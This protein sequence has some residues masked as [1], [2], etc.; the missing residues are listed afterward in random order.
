MFKSP[1]RGRGSSHHAARTKGWPVS[2]R[3]RAFLLIGIIAS[4]LAGVAAPAAA[5]AAPAATPVLNVGLYHGNGGSSFQGFNGNGSAYPNPQNLTSWGGG[6]W[7][8]WGRNGSTDPGGV[9]KSTGQSISTLTAIGPDG[10]PTGLAAASGERPFTFSWS[11]GSAPT[12]GSAAVAGVL[13]QAGGN[14]SSL[15]LSAKLTSQVQRLRVWVSAYDGT[16]VFE[17]TVP[18]LPKYTNKDV[19][20]KTNDHGGVFELDV[21]G[22]GVVDISYTLECPSNGCSADSHV[23]VYAA[24]Y[25]WKGDPPAFSV[26]VTAGQPADFTIVQGQTAPLASSVTT[27]LING[28]VGSVA[29]SSSV[30][31]DAGGSASGLGV[32][33]NP[34]TV[35]PSGGSLPTVSA[36]TITPAVDIA[37]GTY[38]ITV[39][40]VSPDAADVNTANFSVAVLPLTQV[41]FLYRAFPNAADTDGVAPEYEG[42][43]GGIT[44]TGVMN[45]DKSQTYR[46]QFSTATACSTT[47]VAGGTLTAGP[48]IEISTDAQG[49]A[50]F[51]NSVAIAPDAKYISAK[52][53][54]YLAKKADGTSTWTSLGATEAGPCIVVSQPN[55]SWPWAL[56]I[57]AGTNGLVDF[58]ANQYIDDFARSRWYMFQVQPGSRVHVTISNLPKD[59]DAYL[60][61]DI[62][63]AYEDGSGLLQQS[64]EFAPPSYAPPS[65]APPSYAPDS[66]APPSYAPPSY[67]PPSYAPPSYAPPSY[68]PPSYAPPSYAPPSY[69]PPSYAPPSYAPPSY[70]QAN[71]APPSYAP[72]SYAL[73]DATNYSSA[74]TRSLI[75]WDVESGTL[76]ATID[77]NTWNSTGNFYLRVNGKSGLYDIEQAFRVTITTD[78]SVCD[79][80]DPIGSAPA[81]APAAGAETLILWNSQRIAGTSTEKAALVTKL[82]HL[83]SRGDVDGVVVDLGDTSSPFYP[84]MTSL[85]QQADAHTSCVYAQ[86]LVASAARDVV[87]AY[88]QSNPGLKYVVLAGGDD[89]IPFFRYPDPAYLGPES[90][91]VPPVRKDSASEASLRSNYVLGQDEYGASTILSLGASRIPIPDLAVGRLAESASDVVTMIDAYAPGSSATLTTLTPSSAL[92]TGYDFLADTAHAVSDQLTTGMAASATTQQLISEYGTATD[93]SWTAGDLRSALLGQR[94]DIVFLAGH[95]S[96]NEALAAD[97]STRMN[98]S[99]LAASSVNL[100]NSLVF[101]NGCHSGYNLV[102]GAAITGVTE[103]LDWAQAF[104]QKGATLIAGT[105]Y[106]YGDTDLLEYSERIYAEFARQLRVGSGPVSV[107]DALNAAK[108]AYMGS[109]QHL[110]GL[111]EKSIIEAALFGLPMFKVNMTG[112][113]DT[114]PGSSPASLSLTEVGGGLSWADLASTSDTQK[115][116]K[117]L[118]VL[119][120]N[121]TTAGSVMTFWYSGKDGTSVNPGDPILPLDARNV[122]QAGKVL[123]GVVLLNGTYR[124]RTDLSVDGQSYPVV[125]LT[126]TA[127][128]ELGGT[129]LAFGSPTFYPERPWSINY[130]DELAGGST[131]LLLTPAQHRV[132]VPGAADSVLRLYSGLDLRLYYLDSSV[133]PDAPIAAALAPSISN[134]RATVTGTSVTFQA[135]VLGDPTAG[136]ALD[137]WITYTLGPDVDGNGT[138]ASVKLKAPA[139][140]DSSNIWTTDPQTFS[141]P[142]K[143]RFLA[144]AV[145][146]GGAVSIDTNFGQ[147]YGIS[148][149]TVA[150]SLTL[151]LVPDHAPYGG[152]T[153]ATATLSPAV[154]GA[155][156][157]FRLGTATRTASTNAAGVATVTLPLQVTPGAYTATASYPGDGTSIA[158]SAVHPFTV[159]KIQTTAVIS[160]DPAFPL[161]AGSESGVKAV[162]TDGNGDPLDFR[163]LFFVVS[164]VDG[165]GGYTVTRLTDA[166]G[167]AYLGPIPTPFAGGKAYTITAYYA[168]PFTSV[169]DGSSVDTTD[170]VYKGS[171]S[172]LPVPGDPPLVIAKGDQAITFDPIAPKVFGAAPFGV[173]AT[174]SSGLPVTFTSGTPATCSVSG[175]TVTLLAAGACTITASQSGDTT[176]SAATPVTQSVTT[177]K[178]AATVTLTCTAGAPFTY[179]GLPQAPCTATAVSATGATVTVSIGITYDGAASATAAGDYDV[180]AT[181][182]DLNYEGSAAGLVTIVKA[183]LTVTPAD[184]SVAYGSA[185]PAYS[186]TV[187]GFVPGETA[188]TAGG[189]SAP[190]CTSTY[191][192]TTP[193]SSSPV[194]ITC[195]GGAADN[196]AFNTTAKGRLT[197]TK[198]AQPALSITGPASATYGSGDQAITTSGG[199]G[200]GATTFSAGASTACSIVSGKLHVT[201]GT[202]TCQVTAVKAGDGNYLDATAPSFA[203]TIR[204]ADST[205]TVSCP[206]SV[207]FT[208][209]AQTPCSATVTGPASLSQSLTVSYSNNVDAGTATASANYPANANYNASQDSKSFQI[210]PPTYLR[211]TYTGDWFVPSGTAPTLRATVTTM[212]ANGSAGPSVDYAANGVKAVFKIFGASC[213]TACSTPVFTSSPIQVTSAGEVSVVANALVDDAYLVTV[214]LQ[215]SGA[216][217][218]QRAVGAFAQ[219]PGSA[220]FVTGG[221]TIPTDTTAYAVNTKGYFGFNV[222][223]QKSGATG[224]LAYTYRMR[225]VPGSSTATNLASCTTLGTTCRDVDFIIRSTGLTSATTTTASTWPVTGTAIGNAVLQVVDATS[226]ASYGSLVP[227]GLTFRYDAYDAT[228]GPAGDRFGL[229]VYRTSGG[230]QPCTTRRRAAR[231]RR[232]APRLQPTRP[233]SPRARSAHLR[234]TGRAGPGYGASIRPA[235]DPRGHRRRGSFHA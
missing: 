95:F 182:N 22:S 199:A 39:T 80:V 111:H 28:P 56:P 177:T 12:S 59:Y 86:N 10:S 194:D 18:N 145:S 184:A 232:R 151:D 44:V 37:A 218:A 159:D 190:T 78:P 163:T 231:S 96:S 129:H 191:T 108:I 3:A 167:T 72:P 27:S 148:T 227:T 109:T 85:Y 210:L 150:T 168:S 84:R 8:L 48:V 91:Y 193:V 60:F 132:E 206:A 57:K 216:L 113:R 195:S 34:T 2:T 77:A 71:W 213:G 175:S 5:T 228:S 42:A 188:L 118:D 162:V 115:Q 170:Q 235:S 221:G 101:S 70:A 53:I 63:Q 11:D 152:T 104:A 119:N 226:G 38:H 14:G 79:A 164:A 13:P 183:S 215:V 117:L 107:G 173:V 21:A 147:Y 198:A 196:Y 234:A 192:T 33:V 224:S 89:S 223:K 58:A 123:R 4:Q 32:T 137:A 50:Y 202:G 31:T 9:K 230:R 203:V 114:S 149:P 65:Y 106:Q 55:E 222:R 156:I 178:A 131:N 157:T 83:A 121:G 110:S 35:P 180:V 126:A 15:K 181:V 82:G 124:D 93:D 233:P 6:D 125:P 67:A 30:T 142:G 68:A 205:T 45:G 20:G 17:A 186:S 41:P 116:H 217:V 189:Y 76:S 40:G 69:A 141:S 52:A 179:T 165:T 133:A 94:H 81:S 208:G 155:P 54:A 23:T 1:R 74:Q 200:T 128:T 16:G 92:T 209:T 120:A 166:T 158:S 7:R 139:A 169:P 229:S 29:L 90:D 97:F 211:T 66:F 176:W 134:V 26:D 100:K 144:Q 212:L 47:R 153:T 207:L 98:V 225:I 140:G 99:E 51:T 185:A 112:T 49:Q 62:L 127:G 160:H 36:V 172:G 197:I 219:H 24:A 220:T 154:D 187:A 130:F 161:K 61:R 64:A 87:T 102:D 73:Y 75:G 88:R 138:W 146:T 25:T 201:S 122:T 135:T 204:K 103:P 43:G 46:V 214:E 105:G 174:A 19:V 171:T 136:G 143:L